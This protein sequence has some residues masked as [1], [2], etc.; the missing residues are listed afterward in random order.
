MLKSK[1]TKLFVV[2]ML[3]GM[4]ALV[5]IVKAFP[6]AFIEDF[7]NGF[8]E[9]WYPVAYDN[10]TR[11]FTDCGVTFCSE[12]RN[13]GFGNKYL[14][15]KLLPAGVAGTYHDLE[16]HTS[17]FTEPLNQG[18][19][20]P[21]EGHPIHFVAR[22]RTDNGPVGGNGAHFPD[23]SGDAIGTW[24]VGMHNN[25]AGDLDPSG[26]I[27]SISFQWMNEAFSDAF[28]MDGFTS[29]AAA[30]NF[31]LCVKRPV[32]VNLHV[33]TWVKFIWSQ[34]PNGDQTVQFFVNG[35][36]IGTC[37][38]LKNGTLFG[39]PFDQTLVGLNGYIWQ[40]NQV[41]LGTPP[42]ITTSKLVPTYEQQFD[43]NLYTI[44]QN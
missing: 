40:D 14:R 16:F 28:G 2:S 12:F 15:L 29:V 18:P 9:T 43:V 19:W 5:G 17:P 35:Q 21:A 32:T 36:D 13:E 30:N 31:P 4:L 6:S 42:N 10:Q 7:S 26:K 8:R 34:L 38:L 1:G 3:A 23:G 22:I 24:G 44:W 41:Y 33:W 39:Q 20:T 37:T 11:V 27:D 25:A